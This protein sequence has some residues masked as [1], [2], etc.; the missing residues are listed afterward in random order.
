[1]ASCKPFS[2]KFS[3]SAQELFT[4]IAALI[5][6]HGGTITGGPSGGAFSVPVP[7]LGAVA[8]AFSVSGQKIEIHITKRS[9]FLACGTIEKFVKD[10]IPTV[11][12]TAIA[13]F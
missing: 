11:Q 4:K 13:D 10:H 7:V 6:D 3:G 12:K 9:I 1:M 2:V 5:H 8:G